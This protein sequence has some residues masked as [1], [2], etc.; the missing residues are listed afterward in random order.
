MTGVWTPDE[1]TT[2]EYRF[3]RFNY[4]IN[5]DNVRQI[6][7]VHVLKQTD[8]DA[9]VSG[10]VDL[11]Y[12]NDPVPL[13]MNFGP[14]VHANEI[15][16]KLKEQWPELNTKFKIDV[17][18]GGWCQYGWAFSVHSRQRG[19]MKDFSV[20][21][22]ILDQP[23]RNKNPFKEIKTQSEPGVVTMTMPGSV[24][25][26]D[27][28]VPQVV[29]TSN[30]QRSACDN[31]DFVYSS[32][33]TP[34][35]TG[36][37][38]SNGQVPSTVALGDSLIFSYDLKSYSGS[39]KDLTLIIGGV[40]MTNCVSV[41]KTGVTCDVGPSPEGTHEII[42]DLPQAGVVNT[43]FS[44][45][46]SRSIISHSPVIGSKFGGTIVTVSGTGFG[47]GQVVTV[48][49]G[50]SPT[51]CD[52]TGFEVSY[53]TLICSTRANPSIADGATPTLDSISM[54][55]FSI[56]GGEIF[57]LTGSGFTNAPDC[58]GKVFVGSNEA[59]IISW[60]DTEVVAETIAGWKHDNNADTK[61][62]VCNKGFTEEKNTSVKFQINS[63]SGAFTSLYGGRLL[64][65]AGKGFATNT[66][67]ADSLKVNVGSIPCEIQSS[68]KSEII[69]RTG[70]CS[71]NVVKL[72]IGATAILDIDGH[73]S[74][75]IIIEVGQEIHWQWNLQIAGVVPK[76]RF[77]ETN[78][79]FTAESNNF[80]SDI[81]SG[82]QNEFI[83]HFDTKGTFYYSTGLIDSAVIYQSGKITV[84]DA[85][86]KPLKISVTIDDVEAVHNGNSN[87]AQ[88]TNSC[89][90]SGTWSLFIEIKTAPGTC[91]CLLVLI[92]ILEHLI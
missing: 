33:V 16:T 50:G 41:S 11:F 27:H 88:P 43:G 34:D 76:I 44:V 64:T 8:Q 18:R 45:S 82:S 92:V 87:N 26:T 84:V 37:V 25:A 15:K 79:L 9:D 39:L 3:A 23:N 89:S 57:T 86:D 52:S 58:D 32:T 69:C 48:D 42:F 47:A 65:I 28:H 24:T 63:V 7:N 90:L 81:F 29:I 51:E 61:L 62:Y 6:Y 91:M 53:D 22:W 14:D 5:A 10:V 46:I 68:S 38:D 75:D 70:K 49:I 74:S 54:S 1:Q 35:I 31:C 67:E 20:G 4:K 77:Q 85:T 66:K 73:D 80:W 19:R 78:D 59:K 12:G 2:K 60:S 83:K 36:V 17:Y 21:D 13:K 56:I 72:Q 30:G 40:A 55:Q 71:S